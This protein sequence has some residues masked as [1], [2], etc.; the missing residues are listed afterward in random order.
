MA[1]RRQEEGRAPAAEGA[2]AGSRMGGRRL[3]R[4]LTPVVG[5]MAPVV[6]GE[7]AGDG[8]SGAGGENYGRG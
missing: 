4:G 2:R 1:A 5:R 8:G 3:W 7:G 6:A